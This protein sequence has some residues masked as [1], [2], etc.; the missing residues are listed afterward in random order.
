MNEFQLH[1]MKS[2]EKSGL[3]RVVMEDLDSNLGIF[4]SDSLGIGLQSTFSTAKK[5]LLSKDA[6]SSK[7]TYGTGVSLKQHLDSFKD[8]KDIRIKNIQISS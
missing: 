2:E 3:N 8:L 5:S 7:S 6:Q 1:N 4:S